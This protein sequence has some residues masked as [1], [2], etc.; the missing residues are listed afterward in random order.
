MS[1]HRDPLR[2]SSHWHVDCRIETDLPEDSLIGASFV[3]NVTF[4]ALTLT[5]VLL[6]S[7]T[8]YHTLTLRK[9]IRVWEQRIAENKTEVQEIRRMQREYVLESQKIDR[10]YGAIRPT[11]F[12]SEFLAIITQMLPAQVNIDSTEFS[13]DAGTVILRGNLRGSTPVAGTIVGAYVA[14]L[15]KD[16]RLNQRFHLIRVT[17][18][19]RGK[20]KNDEF[21][22]FE[23]TFSL[24]PLPSL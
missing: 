15:R 6:F 13:N 9:Q 11:L 18:L 24:Q 14:S 22:N 8:A 23:L 19:T 21:Q 4:S 1:R 10:A 2:L 17:A 5:M 3:A 7:W 20:G 16:P 12:V